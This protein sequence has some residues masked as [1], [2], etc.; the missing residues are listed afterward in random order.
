MKNK[1]IGCKH[2]TFL[3]D[4]LG[5]ECSPTQQLREFVQNACEAIQRVQRDDP[6]HRGRIVLDFADDWTEACGAA[7][8]SITDNGEGM[9]AEQ[10]DEYM[11]NLSSSGRTQALDANFGVGAKI[12]SLPLNPLGVIFESWKAGEGHMIHV[13]KD[14]EGDFGLKPI[15]DADGLTDFV[16]AIRDDVK[17]ALIESHGTRVVLLGE[18]EDDNTCRPPEGEDAHTEWLIKTLNRRYYRFPANIEISARTSP[19][20][21]DRSSS[22]PR[23]S[24]KGQANMLAACALA[25]GRVQLRGAV[26]HWW[27]M[28]QNDGD[29]LNRADAD[30]STNSQAG[31]GRSYETRG[32]VAVLVRDEL[33]LH[34]F[35]NSGR[36]VMQEF[37][38]TAG[39]T[40]VIIYVEPEHVAI[41]IARTTPQFQGGVPPWSEWGAQFREKMPKELQDYVE[42]LHQRSDTSVDDEI[43]KRMEDLMDL[44]SPPRFQQRTNGATNAD[45]DSLTA[46]GQSTP[47]KPSLRPRP[48]SGLDPAPRPRPHGGH[49]GLDYS[50]RVKPSGPPAARIEP[51]IRPR[52]EWLSKE[53]AT[54]EFQDDCA[55]HYVRPDNTILANPNFRFFEQL[56]DRFERE[57]PNRP[58]ARTVIERHLHSWF[59]Q[60]LVEA[61]LGVQSL[62]SSRSPTWDQA[63]VD[64]MLRPEALTVAV[65]VRCQAVAMIRGACSKSLG[66]SAVDEV[67]AS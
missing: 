43:R 55:A 28:P 47:S 5:E 41:N 18:D 21:A 63:K 2:P 30:G 50:D 53:D 62:I 32:H 52:V 23:R 40:A 38:V 25:S 22:C 29:W 16:P 7:K 31:W 34:R 35:G 6:T 14:D 57:F 11:N 26:A 60:Q 59:G 1:K 45:L 39:S 3:V 48:S 49:R 10:L 44:F 19:W 36:F 17:P 67:Q 27:L 33:Y 37:G 4:K 24:V 58:G 51:P 61:V 15:P 8:L 42:A 64:E 65:C 66:R 56:V 13:C 12:A 20:K 54:K 46:G 9:T